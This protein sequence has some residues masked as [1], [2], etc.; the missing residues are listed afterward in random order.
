[1]KIDMF[2]KGTPQPQP[3][4]RAFVRANGKPGVRTPKKGA[5]VKWRHLV[6]VAAFMHRTRQPMTGAVYVDL[7]F[8]MPR[9]KRHFRTGK[10]AGELL[11]AAEHAHHTQT[12]DIDNLVKLVM[13]V[14]TR[15]EAWGDDCQ[16]DSLKAEKRWAD[17]DGLPPGVEILVG[18]RDDYTEES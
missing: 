15:F 3:R 9:P 13:D 11:P 16:V 7:V 4:G 6:Q 8:H 17:P 2:V 12:P 5:H 1:M 18:E 10:R 14:L